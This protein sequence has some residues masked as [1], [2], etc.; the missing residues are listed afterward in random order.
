MPL[1]VFLAAALLALPPGV[2]PTLLPGADTRDPDEIELAGL[3]ALYPGSILHHPP[4]DLQV[5]NLG[6]FP[7]SVEL[8]R[9]AL[10][11]YYVRVYDLKSSK[12]Q[13][14]DA[15][16]S[17]PLLIIDFRYVVAEAPDAEDFADALA[18]AGLASGPVHAVGAGSSIHEPADLPAPVNPD[19]PAPLVLVLVN[20]Q[21]AGPLEAWLAAFQEKESVLAVGRP[22]AGQPG[23][24]QPAPGHQ[25][26]YIISGELQPESG[27][28]AGTGLLPRFEVD[29]TPEQNKLAYDRVES[30]TDVSAMLRRD[31]VTAAAAANAQTPAPANGTAAPG[32]TPASPAAASDAGDPVLQRAVDV[33]AALQVLGRVPSLKPANASKAA[34]AAP[35]GASSGPG[36]K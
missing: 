15:L 2:D 18:R 9:N 29:V 24:Y 34:D 4:Q 20:G 19:K 33:V 10:N 7:K 14:A 16:A 8:L 27:S 35:A 25:D 26:Y 12:S 17:N 31:H 23:V 30:G 32:T 28:V 6:R 3:A 36:G 5:A 11:I 21:T 22:T 13:L 1:P